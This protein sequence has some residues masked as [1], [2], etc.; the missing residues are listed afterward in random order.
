M[1]QKDINYK[2]IS[3]A[4][5]RVKES[6]SH[7]EVLSIYSKPLASKA[8]LTAKPG[9]DMSKLLASDL[10]AMV[11]GSVMS[12]QSSF[13][14]IYEAS[15]LEAFDLDLIE[16]QLQRIKESA[17]PYQSAERRSLISAAGGGDQLFQIHNDNNDADRLL[18]S[19]GLIEQLRGI[20]L[21]ER[22]ERLQSL[23][24]HLRV[25]VDISD[26]NITL[27]RLVALEMSKVE[28]ESQDVSLLIHGDLDV[29]VKLNES[30]RKLLKESLRVLL[31]NAS[32]YGLGGSAI[33]VSISFEEERL[34]VSVEN[35][36]IVLAPDEIFTQKVRDETESG[37][38][39]GLAKVKQ[40]LLRLGGDISLQLNTEKET[41]KFCIEVDAPEIKLGKKIEAAVMDIEMVKLEE[42]ESL[43]IK[44]VKRIKHKLNK[45]LIVE[46]SSTDMRM[47]QRIAK[48]KLSHIEFFFA[49]NGIEA[50]AILAEQSGI[51]VVASDEM[52]EVMDGTE[53]ANA[54][55][56]K[57]FDIPC[58]LC[59]SNDATPG[60][61]RHL[62]V[63]G[64]VKKPA[65]L[66]RIVSEAEVIF[67][68][69]RAGAESPRAVTELSIS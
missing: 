37:W 20:D 17:G 57:G 61:G 46:D 45:V 3:P 13:N 25:S 8:T 40:D 53:L 10:L 27:R 26:E 2:A 35:S 66:M 31:D 5:R 1:T 50:L 32:R 44:S 42:I 55:K 62:N 58:V 34:N 49:K 23:L 41:S 7:L 54:M 4:I 48:R 30:T 22:T 15:T 63:D 47:Y 59:T 43:S 21:K 9:F 18:R 60:E 14:R 16:S 28:S 12:I 56:S 29:D 19:G 52:M 11:N 24:N 69:I 33:Y 36:G 65:G 6:E 68:R 64:V 39:Y 51:D 67:N 38:G